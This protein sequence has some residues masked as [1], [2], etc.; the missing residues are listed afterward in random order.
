MFSYFVTM[1]F[2]FNAYC[3]SLQ[4]HIF[5]ILLVQILCLKIT[6]RWLQRS[7]RSCLY[8][9][10]ITEQPS[11]KGG[12]PIVVRKIRILFLINRYQVNYANPLL[13]PVSM[14]NCLGPK[15]GFLVIS[16]E[17]LALKT[18]ILFFKPLCARK[19]LKISILFHI[20]AS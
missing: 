5:P 19:Q 3:V 11:N 15:R 7:N 13:Y 14:N 1:S 4:T 8:Y 9:L 6:Q 17:D 10:T 12:Q 20:T 16:V 18:A 2:I